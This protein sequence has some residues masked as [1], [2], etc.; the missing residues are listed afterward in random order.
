MSIDKLKL[1]FGEPYVV[2]DKII[3]RQPSIGEILEYGEKEFYSMLN[4]FVSNPTSYRLRLWD[5]GVDW[6]K[7][8]DY[9]LFAALVHEMDVNQ[10]N[11][12]FGNVD[13]SLFERTI[14]QLNG[15]TSITLYNKK[16]DIE[17]DEKTYENIALYVRTM[18]DIFP[19]V[20]K[21][22]G[23]TTKEAIID[24]D[25]MN[26]ERRKNEEYSSDLLPLIS[27]CLNHPGFKYKK[28]ELRE[29]GIVEFMDSVKRL[30][31]YESTNALLKG[32]YSGM[33]D[34]SKINKEEF[35]F[36]RAIN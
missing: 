26:L 24:E 4:P 34:T 21:A 19:K 11:I 17:I 20:E 23:K 31:I 5:S 7:I 16:Q 36:M 6:N 18:F 22:K 10:T 9:E 1:Y 27:S 13:F 25:R 14:K 3:I 35:N 32:M 15:E 28:N 8:S 2:N 12:L 30:Q 29:V 33:V